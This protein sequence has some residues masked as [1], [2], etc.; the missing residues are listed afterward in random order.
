MDLLSELIP[1][2]N[3]L[4]LRILT[5]QNEE[6]T[7][8]MLDWAHSFARHVYEHNM[9]STDTAA[10][11]FTPPSQMATEEGSEDGQVQEPPTFNLNAHLPFHWVEDMMDSSKQR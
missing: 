10:R 4:G 6:A 1:T 9:V 2:L 3:S 11:L 7:T 8:L 5:E